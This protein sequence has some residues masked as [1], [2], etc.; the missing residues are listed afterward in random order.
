M[1]QSIINLIRSH[2]H[3]THSH[4]VHAHLALHLSWHLAHLSCTAPT[5]RPRS[6]HGVVYHH[7]SKLALAALLGELLLGV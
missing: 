4:G 5:D 7:G 1:C 3:S 6:T 2:W